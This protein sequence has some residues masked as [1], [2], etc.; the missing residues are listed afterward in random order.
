[1]VNLITTYWSR[2][3]S[4]RLFFSMTNTNLTR[5]RRFS[6]LV[7]KSDFS[8]CDQ[9]PVLH[10]AGAEVRNRYHVLLRQRKGNVVIA[11]EKFQNFRPD[12]GSVRRL[13]ERWF[14]RPFNIIMNYFTKV[15][16][17]FLKATKYWSEKLTL[18]FRAKQNLNRKCNNQEYLAT[19]MLKG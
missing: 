7:K 8:V 16:M 17:Y 4:A 3:Y 15:L 10:G 9:A 2:I 13:L 6:C 14:A 11:F 12:V 18:I 5:E 1:M 19:I